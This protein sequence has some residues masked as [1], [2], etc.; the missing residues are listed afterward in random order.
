MA[1]I[2]TVVAKST[3]QATEVSTATP[4][5]LDGASR[6]TLK[7]DPDAVATMTRGVTGV[8]D[9]EVVLDDG[10]RIVIKD[11]FVNHAGELSEL[12][13]EDQDG[14]LWWL[15]PDPQT[16]G[17]ML[18]GDATSIPV[19]SAVAASEEGALGVAAATGAGLSGSTLAPAKEFFAAW[20]KRCAA[21]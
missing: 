1:E 6:V 15:R 12:V 2:A 13:L 10:S 9:L 11:Y 21:G 7:V 20:K 8:D 5:V 3:G 16:G 14:G 19:A 17:F 4:V 18:A